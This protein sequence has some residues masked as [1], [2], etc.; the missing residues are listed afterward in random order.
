[1]IKLLSWLPAIVAPLLGILEAVLKFLKEALTL[2][3]TILFPIIPNAK[4]KV[5]VTKL[6]ALVDKAYDVLSGAK[7]SILKYI[8]VI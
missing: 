2:I 8:G 7:D 6:R 5:I 4:F 3:V 1:M